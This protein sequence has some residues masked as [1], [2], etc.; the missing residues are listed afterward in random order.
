M[1]HH[2]KESVHVSNK[3]KTARHASSGTLKL[4]L[5]LDFQFV[6]VKF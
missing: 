5:S 2:W 1:P 4:L 6:N 3:L